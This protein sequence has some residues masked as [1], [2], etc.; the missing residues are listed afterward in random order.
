MPNTNNVNT[1]GTVLTAW[2]DS[3]PARKTNIAVNPTLQGLDWNLSQG[4]CCPDFQA[5]SSLYIFQQKLSVCISH[6]SDTCYTDTHL[7][8]LNLITLRM[9]IQWRE[10]IMTLLIMHFSPSSCY[11][12]LLVSTN[13]PLHPV[14]KQPKS[15]FFLLCQ[16]QVSSHPYKMTEKQKIL[17][18]MVASTPT[19]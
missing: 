19:I 18:W 17:N 6:H 13:S 16:S 5:V 7:I 4:T 10:H 8:P 14:H 12:I 11:I 3:W 2:W 1:Q 15:M 9:N